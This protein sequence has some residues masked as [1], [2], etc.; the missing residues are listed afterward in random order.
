MTSRTCNLCEGAGHGPCAAIAVGKH[1][2]ISGFYTPGFSPCTFEV[3]GFRFGTLLCVE[4]QFGELWVEQRDLGVDCVLFSSYSDDPIFDVIAR[5]NAAANS[6]WVSV[7]VPAPCSAAMASTVIG[8]HGLHLAHANPGEADLLCVDLDRNDPALDI[9]LNKAAPWRRR[10][11]TGVLYAPHSS[12]E[13]RS[14]DHT[15]I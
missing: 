15:L 12:T 8:P 3:D 1:S 6:Y 2:E 9:A 4:I 5:G 14:T 10:A 11:A 13:T 7:A